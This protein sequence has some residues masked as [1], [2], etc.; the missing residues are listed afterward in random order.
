MAQRYTLEHET[1]PETDSNRDLARRD[2]Q[3]IAEQSAASQGETDIH[4]GKKFAETE[5]IL[6]ARAE[7]R[8]AMASEPEAAGGGPDQH[9]G[10][11]EEQVTPSP[12]PP[13]SGAVADE[14]GMPGMARHRREGR[15]RTGRR[16]SR[17]TVSD[18][19]PPLGAMLAEELPPTAEQVLAETPG[20]LLGAFADQVTRSLRGVGEAA[21][22]LRT[23]GRE[24]AGLPFEALRLALR[25]GRSFL[26]RSPRRA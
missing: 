13:S 26:H 11:T 4:Y 19:T 1:V 21:R 16:A 24:L 20:E 3:R 15:R 12:G 7:E 2:K 8:A 6:K 14:A 10:S 18:R 22:Q 5:A 9:L 17:S 23:A 25:V